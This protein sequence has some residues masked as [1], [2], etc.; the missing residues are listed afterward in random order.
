MWKRK[1]IILSFPIYFW[2]WCFTEAVETLTK[3]VDMTSDVVIFCWSVQTTIFLRVH[4]C[5]P[6]FSFRYLIFPLMWTEN[7]CIAGAGGLR[8]I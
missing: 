2:S 5:I 6:L 3:T 1:E 8:N 4:G 7:T